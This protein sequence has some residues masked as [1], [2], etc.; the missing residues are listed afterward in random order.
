MQN[1]QNINNIKFIYLVSIVSFETLCEY[2]QDHAH[3][4]F[5]SYDLAKKYVRE[6]FK[7]E[8]R[9]EH[10]EHEEDDFF[11]DKDLYDDKVNEYFKYVSFEDDIMVIIKRLKVKYE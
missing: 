6:V 4:V 8:E 11:L 9:E 5:A 7:N 1:T 3:E 10:G 2:Q